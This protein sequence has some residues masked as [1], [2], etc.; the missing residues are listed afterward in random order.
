MSQK[1]KEGKGKIKELFKAWKI[2]ITS[3]SIC[4]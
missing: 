2:I 4:K 1:S 3:Y